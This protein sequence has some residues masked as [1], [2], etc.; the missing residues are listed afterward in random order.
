MVSQ[1]GRGPALPHR[2]H[3]LANRDSE[4]QIKKAG[5]RDNVGRLTKTPD[6]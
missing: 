6:L 2:G 1:S 4:S 5:L 3:L